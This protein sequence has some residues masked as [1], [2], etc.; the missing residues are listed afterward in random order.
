MQPPTASEITDE[1]T[2]LL[3]ERSS[4]SLGIVVP[5]EAGARF[6]RYL[7]RGRV[8]AGAMGEVYEAF[9]PDLDRRIAIKIVHTRAA[10][11]PD[12]QLN[13][14][15]EAN[16]LARLSH[17][18]VVHVFDAGTHDGRVYVAMEFVEG[19]TFLA[20]LRADGARR[21]REIV[22]MF[23]EAGRGLAA[24]HAA[25][26]VHGD[27]KPT[28]V[29]VG[30]DGRAR[31]FDFGVARSTAEGADLLTSLDGRSSGAH[32]LTVTTVR[33]TP[34]YMAPELFRDGVAH[35]AADQFA[36]CVALYE[37]LWG[38]RPFAGE[39]VKEL[40]ANVQAGNV[41][42]P[43]S[44]D[45]PAALRRIVMRGLQVHVWKR[46]ADMPQLLDALERVLGRRRRAA[47]AVAVLVPGLAL[48]GGALVAGERTS[49]CAAAEERVAK[50]W[51]EPRREA[52]RTAFAA[53]GKAFAD[54]AG[55]RVVA[56]M[57]EYATR[58]SDAYRDVCERARTDDVP[59]AE[60]DGG[61]ACLSEAMLELGATADLLAAADSV[62]AREALHAVARL[63]DPAACGDATA[64][65]IVEPTDPASAT[66][67]AHV[68][69]EIAE[70]RALTRAAKFEEAVKRSRPVVEAAAAFPGTSIDAEA[71]LTLAT[72]LDLS[73][74]TA[75]AEPAYFDAIEVAAAA[76]HTAVEREA[77]ANLVR[78]ATVTARYPDAHRYS[79]QAM[80]LIGRA[81]GDDRIEVAVHMN[82]AG[83]LLAEAEYDAAI[84]EFERGLELGERVLSADDGRIAGMLNN[85][86]AVYGSRGDHERALEY[87]QRAYVL[88]HDALGDEHP[89][90]ATCMSNLAVTYERLGDNERALQLYRNVVE[91]RSQ[92]FGPDHAEVAV[93]LHNLGSILS[94][95]GRSKE[96]LELYARALTIKQ[97]TLGP[98]HPST[99][100][101]ESNIGDALVLER[102][103]EEAIPYLERA[104]DTLR[105]R[106]GPDHPNLG[107]AL[108]SL[109]EA[110][111]GAGRPERAIEPL[112]QTLRIRLERKVDPVDVAR[113]RFA[114]ARALVATGDSERGR[115]LAGEAEGELEVLAPRGAPELA[116]LRAWKKKSL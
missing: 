37:A 7:I 53:V 96:A 113:T 56:R 73:G 23:I 86:G 31:V 15:A 19:T 69:Q 10:A 57:D 66:V 87:F 84:A 43:P 21:W 17:P 22:A 6:G 92:A 30:A 8:G 104:V 28:N 89:D 71:R 49:P 39:H 110:E 77:W 58:W 36:F 16:A 24:A 2:Q 109:G 61:M 60:L 80:A 41:R 106:L 72:A 40:R 62:V 46:F 34:G 90:T 33:G 47:L 45:V 70:I 115:T 82:T 94:N 105:N 79:R 63:P 95:L 11:D 111:L 3:G 52:V 112:E 25:G 27:F 42:E 1:D 38:Q 107:F 93:A 83:L 13:L 20:W 29:M 67:V 114:L 54:E 35:P 97:A 65:D 100:I 91:I 51:D 99:A 88:K 18:N 55:V 14:V 98:E 68:R 116:A 102:R 75:D 59:S 26:M 76:K 4:T 44:A 64:T 103:H 50:V 85:L 108:F 5:L 78:V 81:G 48:L 12:A 9:D 32:R 101:T 74:N